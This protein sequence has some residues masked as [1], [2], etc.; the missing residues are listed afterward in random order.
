MIQTVLGQIPAQELS[1]TLPH[2]HISIDLRALVSPPP[3]ESKRDV[4]YQKL[5]LSNVGYTLNNPYALLDNAVI[6]DDAVMTYELLQYKR[7]GGVSIVDVT[8]RDIAR[9]PQKLQSLSK[10][11]GVN[12][13]A[14]CGYYISG[15]HPNNFAAMSTE[16]IAQEMYDELKKGMDDTDIK[17]GVIGEIGTSAQITDNEW[18]SVHAAALVH[19]QT[20]AGIHVHTSLWE[21]NG[22][23]VMHYLTNL[24]VPAN[25]IC[26]DHIDVD[27]RYDYLVEL[28]HAGGLIEFDN[29]GKEYYISGRDRYYMQGRF[30][31]DL[32][33]VQ[34]I[35][36]LIADGFIDHI[37]VTNDICL[38]SLLHSYG[39]RGYDHILTNI[40]P[41][42]EDLNITNAQIDTLLIT[43][44]AQ[45]LDL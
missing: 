12:I 10:E 26:I 38:K 35:N 45:F 30:A 7:A 20:G 22:L 15:S 5:S 17:A 19:A 36:R 6:D 25:K 9:D 34:M 3:D 21:T 40:I 44:P 11:T 2:E 13:I 29:F 1:Y 39:G 32:E 33:R 4:F 23:A 18:K 27:L 37:L 41:M 8:L 42:M 43:N 14:G 24:G 31:Y 28:C 16:D